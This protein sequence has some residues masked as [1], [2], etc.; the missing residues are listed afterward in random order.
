MTKDEL[1]VK[2]QLEI[3]R[4]K[5][6]QDHNKRMLK[7][8]FGEF[9]SCGAPLNDNILK[10]DRTQLLWCLDVYIIIEDIIP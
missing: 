2:Q 4:L 6:N 10:F 9:Y 3:E 7:K 8:L 5:S 1:I